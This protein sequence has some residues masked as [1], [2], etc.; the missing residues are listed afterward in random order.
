M[1]GDKEEERIHIGLVAVAEVEVVMIVIV[2]LVAVV[3]V[4]LGMTFSQDALCY[5]VAKEI[6]ELGNFEHLP[7]SI[8]G[9]DHPGQSHHPCNRWTGADAEYRNGS[10]SQCWWAP[11]AFGVKVRA[12]G[13]M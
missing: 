11:P 6:V 1:V 7:S 2:V 9:F 3:A 5:L 10:W 13:K 12:G 4:V 8:P